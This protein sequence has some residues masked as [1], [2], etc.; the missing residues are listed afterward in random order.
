MTVG[1]LAL[2]DY[3]PLR[4]DPRFNASLRKIGFKK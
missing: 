4:P 1:I 2:P 3:D